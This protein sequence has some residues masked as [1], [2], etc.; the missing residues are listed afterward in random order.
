MNQK[1]I[2]KNETSFLESQKKEHSEKSAQFSRIIIVMIIVLTIIISYD[3]TT[4]INYLGEKDLENRT[5][6][7]NIKKCGYIECAKEEVR[8]EITYQLPNI[9]RITQ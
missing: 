7:K 1:D 6:E 4:Y 3:L 8:N 9:S 2:L 5:Q